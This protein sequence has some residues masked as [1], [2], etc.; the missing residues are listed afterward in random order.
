[1]SMGEFRKVFP[2]L[3]INELK[4]LIYWLEKVLENFEV[5]RNWKVTSLD[6]EISFT[7]PNLNFAIRG[8]PLTRKG[9]VFRVYLW[10]EFLPPFNVEGSDFWLNFR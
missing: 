7:E 6:T 3:T 10:A 8:G 5:F 2:C 1:M 9:V 4:D